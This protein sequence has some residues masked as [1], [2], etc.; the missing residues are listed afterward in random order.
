MNHATLLLYLLLFQQQT[1]GPV[2]EDE[3]TR[4]DDTLAR[5]GYIT[6]IIY[7]LVYRRIGVQVSTELHTYALTPAQHLVTL[8]MFR[9]V[10]GHVLQEVSQT[11]LVVVLLNRAHTLGNVELGTVF[12]PCVVTDVISQ[13]VVQLTDTHVGVHRN[14]RHLHALLGYSHDAYQHH[15]S[16]E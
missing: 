15:G 10:E 8:E 7:R 14:R 4:V 12:G 16:N 9:A 3:Q 13:S 6:N 5:R 1:V 2:E 11:T